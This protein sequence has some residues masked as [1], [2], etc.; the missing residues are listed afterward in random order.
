MRVFFEVAT[1]HQSVNTV[2]KSA[3]RR[4][5]SQIF[6]ALFG[7]DI[8]RFCRM[9]RKQH[10]DLVLDAQCNFKS[11]MITRLARG[12]R[13]GLDKASAAESIAALVYQDHHRVEKGL[14]AID[15]LR[16]LFSK[17]LGYTLP[18]SAPDFAISLD[19]L[20]PLSIELP[21]PYLIFIHN[22]SWESKCWPENYWLDLI[23]RAKQSNLQV[24]IPWGNA[25]EKARAQRLAHNQDNVILL[26]QITLSQAAYI[27][28]NA[29][30][31]ICVDTGLG[32]LTAALNTPSVSLYGPTDPGLIGTTGQLQANLQADFPC[33]PCYH[34]TCTYTAPSDEQPACFMKLLPDVVWRQLMT[35]LDN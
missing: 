5:R 20:V 25:V 35:L 32:H 11:A 7:G 12:R 9:L 23:K 13:V 28:K 26:P 27:I 34:K 22:A 4:W 8:L 19:K 18:T 10:Y 3:H 29:K 33:A 21:K 16:L 24:V 1:W 17:A 6:K 31:A 14:H 15:R 2:I 30:A